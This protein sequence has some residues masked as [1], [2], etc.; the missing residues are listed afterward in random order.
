MSGAKVRLL[1]SQW[2]K[3]LKF[4]AAIES[5]F[6]HIG[7]DSAYVKHVTS[8]DFRSR[9]VKKNKQIK[10]SLWGMMDFDWRAMRLIDTPLVQRLRTVKQLGFTYL[11]YPTGEYSRFPHALGV[12]HVVIEFLRAIDRRAETA[13][14]PGG[15]QFVKFQETGLKECDVIHA[16]LLHDAGHLPFS[17]VPEKIMDARPSLF[18]AGKKT[19]G[20]LQAEANY[21]TGRKLKS[22]EVLSLVLILS[23]RF[24]TVYTDFVRDG[25]DDADESLIN[26]ACL[27]AGVPP[28]NE[29]SGIPE[30][31]SSASVDADK[32]D[33]VNR[34]ARNC[35]IPVGVD[36][37]R[38]FLRSAIVRA[39]K[40]YIETHGLGEADTAQKYFF[41]VNSTGLDTIDEIIESRA[42][43]YQRVYFHAVTR[44][45]ERL[46]TRALEANALTA[47]DRNLRDLFGIW[48][49][50]DVTILE[51]MRTSDK[52]EV[53][54]LASRLILRNLPKRA[55]TFSP[56]VTGVRMPVEG[57]LPGVDGRS[58][59]NVTKQVN[60][61]TI[62]EYLRHDKL[63]EG[64]GEKIENEIRAE[65]K[66]ICRHLRRSKNELQIPRR[67][68]PECLIIV[69]T[70]RED[71]KKHNQIICQGDRLLRVS[72]Y[73]NS[74][75]QKY[76]FELIKEVGYL[77][78][79]DEWRGIVFV[80]SRVVIARIDNKIGKA[81]LT[82]SHLE[83]AQVSGEADT[84]G[85]GDSDALVKKRVVEVRY[86]RRYLPDYEHVILRS[87]VS[88]HRIDDLE[89]A[90]NQSRYF[91][92][93]P[94]ACKPVA[95]DDSNVLKIAHSLRTFTGDWSWQITPKSVATFLS[96]FPPDLRDQTA[97]LL[98]KIKMIDA[99]NV[100][101][102]FRLAMRDLREGFCVVPFSGTSGTKIWYGLKRDLA[103]EERA[104]FH[105]GLADALR[106]DG[107][108][109]IVFVDDNSSSAVQA[110][111]QF[112][113]W[114]GVD[115]SKW[116]KECRDEDDLQGAL[117][118][119]VISF[120]RTRETLLWVC[121]GRTEANTVLTKC[122]K[123]YGLNGFR[124]LRWKDD[125]GQSFKGS[126]ELKTFLTDVGRSLIA[127][128][129][130]Q[131]AYAG[132]TP[133]ERDS[134]RKDAFGYNG[135]GALVTTSLNV[136]TSTVTAL[137]LPGLAGDVPWMPLLIRNNKMRHLVIA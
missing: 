46:F 62:E 67:K 36:V 65:V 21:A 100:S 134:C 79:D 33:Y 83:E 64:F 56:S 76:A 101:H 127:W 130:Y 17:H 63:L 97:E 72:D 128:S 40:T 108:S 12:A 98:L 74:R 117:S 129:R 113:S 60:N 54:S 2:Q 118:P 91:S 3:D 26:I 47:T 7:F 27:V 14:R 70:A 37:A 77:L 110:R 68:G 19:M 137:W 55:Y 132:C 105:V 85:E 90:L 88:P 22:A 35:G 69:G 119:D 11:T 9:L 84:D 121:A 49:H 120:L 126:N 71:Q 87:S 10:D 43:L 96:Q 112:L 1:R 30:I 53:S 58:M 42:A 136:P 123:K 41:V 5:A 89:L 94:W 81:P 80:A 39:P 99:E 114:L 20:T 75:E 86:M 52:K 13:P 82:E 50:S 24:G 115:R 78:C 66:N 32:I 124:G 104:S 48:S 44:T 8:T 95:S 133:I 107:K 16:A 122:L 25:E 28:T 29:L 73:T 125:L 135:V 109:P 18:T 102:S 34:D 106:S 59:L 23:N 4:Q 31:I 38:V 111:A 93:K 6:D 131:K 116:P 103:N 61:S 92:D 51:Q 45:A 57:I 15:L